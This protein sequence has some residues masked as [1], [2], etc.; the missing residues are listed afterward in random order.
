MLNS[1]V[2]GHT[3]D[4]SC[5]WSRSAASGKADFLWWV[6]L[7]S[8]LCLC[9]S[10]VQ[11]ATTHFVARLLDIVCS[12]LIPVLPHLLQLQPH[13]RPASSLRT[14]AA[15][16]TP[17]LARSL[18][19]LHSALQR[20]RPQ[21]CHQNSNRL[22][23]EWPPKPPCT[24]LLPASHYYLSSVNASKPSPICCRLFG[25]AKTPT[26]CHTFVVMPRDVKACW[27]TATVLTSDFMI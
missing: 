9:V 21:L 18:L 15:R 1:Y 8:S 20:G 27:L 19:A 3:Q 4:T 2:S 25:P 17:P 5:P 14:S 6:F 24:P 13:K 11:W 7:R 22:D 16:L 26:D 23:L 10:E 12:L